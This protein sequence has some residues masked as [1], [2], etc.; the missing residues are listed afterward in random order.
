[1]ARGITPGE[2]AWAQAERANIR[3]RMDTV[4]TPGTAL[5]MPTVPGPAPFREEDQESLDDYRAR[6]LEMLCPAGHAGLPQ[7]SMPAGTVDGGPVGLS[8]VGA[9]GMDRGLLALG[10]RSG[11]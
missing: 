6:A 2:F 4:L 11:G 10:E 7:L 1:M 8:L 5:V 9:R 3:A